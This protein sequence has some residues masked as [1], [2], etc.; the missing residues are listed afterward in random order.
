M[1]VDDGPELPLGVGELPALEA[2]LRDT[3]L[4]LREEVVGG[5][6]ALDPVALGPG[7]IEHEDGRR[8]LRVVALA[9]PDEGFRVIAH[10]KARGDEVLGDQLRHALIGVHLGIQPST[11]SSHR[12]GAEVEQDGLAGR[13]RFTEDGVD[14]VAPVDLVCHLRSPEGSSCVRRWKRGGAKATF[15]DMTIANPGASRS[16]QTPRLAPSGAARTV[17]LAFHFVALLAVGAALALA[18]IDP[19]AYRALVQE[20][21]PVE[22]WTAVVFA[23][24]GVVG[25]LKAIRER[26]VFDGLVAL[27][28]L[29][30]AG[31]E[32]SWGQR[33]IGF[34][35]PAAFL[36]HNTQQE[37]NV[38]NFAELFGR[39]KWSLIAA[40]AGYGFLLPGVA[41]WSRGRRLLD[42]LGAT[43]PPAPLV[44]WFTAAVAL[45]LWYPLEF[46]GE[47][48]E[49]LAGWLFLASRVRGGRGLLALAAATFAAALVMVPVSDGIA[50][51]DPARITCARHEAAAL[52]T[53]LR[54]GAATERL[55]DAR[56]VHKRAWSAAEEGYVD[57]DATRRFHAASCSGAAAEDAS[58]RRAFGI[59]PWGT[60]YWIRARAGELS[61]YSF[62]PNRRRDGAIAGDDV[63]AGATR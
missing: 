52:L 28:C 56:S 20:D 5:E 51:R 44:P 32:I 54:A 19:D 39:P 9:K 10:V 13:A 11:A 23:A 34:T 30:V 55:L 26:R 33:L 14:I 59:D 6:E 42:R 16:G 50:A 3:E 15:N 4:E 18:R 37:L 25:A 47:W 41:L 24:A 2:H 1:G 48:V 17:P 36:A 60:A 53:D 7:R 63:V 21:R 29:F 62:G 38:H 12:G 49:L 45:L 31:E 22:W 8:P 58:K 61:V 57:W 46:T 43:P 35:P 27:F 40:L